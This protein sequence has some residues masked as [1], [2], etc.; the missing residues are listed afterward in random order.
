VLDE[1]RV[2]LIITDLVGVVGQ[3]DPWAIV[4]VLRTAVG[5]GTPIVVC[6][7]RSNAADE[8]AILRGA[9]GVIAKPFDLDEMLEL[10]IDR[11]RS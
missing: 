9:S 4:D 2:D 3:S 11:L 10:A 1:V 8:E 7:G 5:D 6:T